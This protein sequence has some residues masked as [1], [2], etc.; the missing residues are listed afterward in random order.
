[1]VTLTLQNVKK[2]FGADVLFS[3]V[4]F[5]IEEGEK[6]GLVGANRLR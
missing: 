1:M 3:D 5:R 6:V 2:E 4:S